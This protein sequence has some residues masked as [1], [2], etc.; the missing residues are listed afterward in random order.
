MLNNGS[1]VFK[2]MLSPRFNEGYELAS[3]PAPTEITLPEDNAVALTVLCQVIHLRN[4]AIPIPLPSDVLLKLS[5]VADKYD[6]IEA[7]APTVQLSVARYLPISNYTSGSVLLSMTY[8]MPNPKLFAQVAAELVMKTTGQLRLIDVPDVDLPPVLS[9]VIGN[10]T[11]LT[12]RF[13]TY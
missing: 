7:I 6:C 10:S 13:D 11:V 2:A 12:L 3:S 8:F 5:F 4:T 9:Q 1:S